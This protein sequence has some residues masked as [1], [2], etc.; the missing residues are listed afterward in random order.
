PVSVD[1]ATYKAEFLAHYY[2][3]RLRPRAAFTMG[4]VMYWA[5]LAMVAPGIAN[6]LLRGPGIGAA[7]RT[8]A[9]FT[10]KREAPEFAAESFQNWFF[11]RTAKSNPDATPVILWPDTFN[12]HFLPGTAKAAVA[13]LEAA[14]YR[15]IVPRAR[16]CCGRPL[17]DYGMLNLARRQLEQII[18]V[19]RPA[20]RAGVPVV[21]LEPS[22][23]SVFR[24]ELTN[25]MP[26]DEDALRLA[27]QT[28]T[29]PELLMA[30][31]SWR[32]PPFA[33]K[34]LVQAHCHHRAVLD[35]GAQEKM[36][37]AM[38]VERVP[39]RA[40]CCGHAGSFGYE[41]EHYELSMT[42]AEQALLPAVRKAGDDTLIVADGFSCRE[43]IRH[44]AGRNALHPA[45]L[46]ALALKRKELPV[47]EAERS[48]VE[49][50]AHARP[51]DVA[52][53]AVAAVA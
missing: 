10:T 43:Q 27:A 52:I 15:V 16:L 31:E 25:L 18:A 41:A 6:L 24:D 47:A 5:R 9:G 8:L 40:G 46:L 12:N 33:A 20:I 30:K 35:E 32:P 4:L 7:I 3:G 14:G 21:G 34:V 44:G 13:V 11:R 39:N 36:L 48:F 28:K 1:M 17:Y 42:I 26:D 51:R 50:P 2:E 29:L 19:L 22:C 37:A 23:V 38:G 49:V 45:E 53:A